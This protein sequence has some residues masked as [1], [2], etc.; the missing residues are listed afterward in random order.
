MTVLGSG[1]SEADKGP[2][3]CS[4][5]K[6]LS[7]Q[8]TQRTFSSRPAFPDKRQAKCHQPCGHKSHA[9]SN[10]ASP[11]LKHILAQYWSSVVWQ[12]HICDHAVKAWQSTTLC[13]HDKSDCPFP[14]LHSLHWSKAR[15]NAQR[16]VKP[17]RTLHSFLFTPPMSAAPL[18]YVM[19][20]QR[21]FHWQ[22][23]L[24]ETRGG[25]TRT[26]RMG[27]PDWKWKIIKENRVTKTKWLQWLHVTC[28]ISTDISAMCL[29]FQFFIYNTTEHLS[30]LKVCLCAHLTGGL[31]IQSALS[32]LNFRASRGVQPFGVPAPH[33]TDVLGHTWNILWHVI[34]KKSRFKWIYGFVLG[35]IHSHPGRPQVG[36][37][38]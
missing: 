6:P 32:Y 9:N 33:W 26:S 4:H 38:R 5:W 16:V 24:T 35:R 17:S 10:L 8:A 18:D 23:G 22:K 14:L 28:W 13:A 27:M 7:A 3:Y 12:G 1:I 37:P 11:G 21:V 36:H 20:L 34:T 19:Q 2:V 25:R 15:F 30:L 29:P 31:H